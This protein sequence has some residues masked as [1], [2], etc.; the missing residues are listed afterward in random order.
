MPIGAVVVDP[1]L[2]Q[3]IA[4]GHDLRGGNHPLQHA[5]MVTIDLVA[6]SQ[7]GGMWPLI[8]KSCRPLIL[9]IPQDP[10]HNYDVSDFR[11]YSIYFELSL[12]SPRN[13]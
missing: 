7:G 10:C 1:A 6:R 12:T 11:F 8:S 13:Q 4:K 3:V 2:N 5:V 9:S